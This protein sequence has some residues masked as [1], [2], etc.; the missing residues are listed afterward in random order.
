M[1]YPRFLDIW[2]NLDSEIEVS[3]SGSTGTPKKIFL[4]KRMMRESAER[5]NNFFNISAA[6]HLH[7]CISPDFIGGKMMAVRAE[8]AGC[9]FSWENPSNRP[10]ADLPKNRVLDLVA[11]VP[12]QMN[13][14][15]DSLSRLPDIKNIIVGGAPIPSIL[16]GKI[17][18]SGINAYETYGMTETASHIAL[19]K[20][21]SDRIPFVT[22][23]NIGIEKSDSGTLVINLPGQP[24]VITTDLCE[25]VSERE[26][27]IIGRKDNIIITGA[28][29]VNPLDIEERIRQ[30]IPQ[31]FIVTAFPHNLWGERIVL[32]IEGRDFFSSDSLMKQISEVLPAW[33]KPKEIIFVDKLPETSNGKL[34][35]SKNPEDYRS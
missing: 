11:V 27:F 8:L 29:K 6:S 7:S 34:K 20:I 19:R 28:K 12:S 14:I 17:H 1:D 33:Q 4:E 26:F 15:T 30:F 31:R 21:T 35:R 32:I 3:T 2:R 10:L 16:R 24:P 25:I 23:E 5:T 22:F 9:G 18:E 13:F